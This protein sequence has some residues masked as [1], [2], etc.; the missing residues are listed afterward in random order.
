M[1]N[2]S[3]KIFAGLVYYTG[4][5]DRPAACLIWP[6]G[7]PSTTSNTQPAVWFLRFGNVKRIT[8]KNNFKSDKS[9]NCRFFTK[10]RFLQS[11]M[12]V[13]CKWVANHTQNHSLE[14]C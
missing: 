6:I 10:S 2:N 13:F 1:D 3:K 5:N 11:K 7:H 8:T 12:I 9:K 4:R 14:M